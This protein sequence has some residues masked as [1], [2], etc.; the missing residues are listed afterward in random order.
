MNLRA[1]I[2]KEAANRFKSGF[3]VTKVELEGP[4]YRGHGDEIEWLSVRMFQG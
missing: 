1:A 4:F 3:L 2:A